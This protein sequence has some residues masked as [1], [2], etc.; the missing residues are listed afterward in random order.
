MARQDERET[1][2]RMKPRSL[3]TCNHQKE[4]LSYSGERKASQRE[5]L[6]FS[7][8]LFFYPQMKTNFS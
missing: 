2:I 3:P 5:N 6:I 7:I 1:R 4:L 8:F